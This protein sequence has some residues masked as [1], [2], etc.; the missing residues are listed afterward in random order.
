MLQKR[1]KREGNSLHDI[2]NKVVL[3]LQSELKVLC[4]LNNSVRTCL[5]CIIPLTRMNKDN[6]ARPIKEGIVIKSHQV[7]FINSAL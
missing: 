4:K 5:S 3:F 6:T 1:D 7:L 2:C